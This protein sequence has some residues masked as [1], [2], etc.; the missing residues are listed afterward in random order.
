[1]ET[2]F[3]MQCIP[4]E[5]VQILEQN[6]TPQPGTVKGWTQMYAL[7]GQDYVLT[8][9]RAPWR[10]SSDFPERWRRQP[11][12]PCE[13]EGYQRERV[14]LGFPRVCPS[15][16]SS[17]VPNP[18]C[19]SRPGCHDAVTDVTRAATWEPLTRGSCSP[20]PKLISYSVV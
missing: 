7:L 15:D 1:M 10:S 5:E 2:Q 9:T 13:S 11:G 12:S 19:S 6:Q 18:Q 14:S 8:L 4:F 20:L 16:L 17:Y 3:R